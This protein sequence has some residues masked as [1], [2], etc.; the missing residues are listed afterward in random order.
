MYARR[1]YGLECKNYKIVCFYDNDKTKWGQKICGIPVRRWEK[2]DNIKIIIASSW[3]EEI[4]DQL[5]ACNLR[6]LDDVIPYFFLSA[7]SLS[8]DLL[9]KY[10]YVG[11]GNNQFVFERLKDTGKQI[12]VIYGNCQTI[13]LRE[14]LLLNISFARKYFFIVI[15]AVCDYDAGEE[16]RQLW[17]L[18]LDDTEFWKQIDLFIC[19]NVHES[20]KYC[21]RLATDKVMKKLSSSC[22]VIKILNVFFDGYFVQRKTNSNNLMKELHQSGLFPFG[23]KYVDELLGK[24]FLVDEIL[25]QIKD[26]DF[27][28]A[29]IIECAVNQSLE[30]LKNREKQVDVAISDYIE[31]QYKEKQLFYSPNHPINTVLIEYAKRIIHFMG[32]IDIPINEDLVYMKVGCLKGQDIPIYPCVLQYLG[33]DEYDCLYYTNR[34][35][36]PEFLFGFEEYIRK[37]ILYCSDNNE[38]DVV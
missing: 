13:M 20:N 37:Y 14:I 1:V 23:D 15:P 34:Y 25:E 17:N 7:S 19:Q 29:D 3:W 24:G 16:A 10:Q 31:A 33:L 32:L 5:L 6:F 21:S 11:N 38:H 9:R 35:L 30:E 36:E 22:K 8:Y 26:R 4:V 27:L 12:A 2:S 28:T 18:L